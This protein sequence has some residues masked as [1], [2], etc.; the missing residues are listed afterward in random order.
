LDETLRALA[1]PVPERPPLRAISDMVIRLS[2]I[3]WENHEL[4]SNL[5]FAAALG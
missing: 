3:F 1:L 5:Q 4:T 2:Y